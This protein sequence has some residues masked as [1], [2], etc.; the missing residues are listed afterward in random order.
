MAV[1]LLHRLVVTGP[2]EAVADLSRRL[3]R[4]AVRKSGRLTWRERNPFSFRRL[5]QLAP[6]AYRIEPV[7]PY[8]PY[9]ASDWPLVALPG[10]RAEVRYQFSTRNLELQDFVRVLSSQFPIVT[11][12]LLTH[13]LDDGEVAAY[14]VRNGRVRHWLLPEA[15]QDSHWNSARRKF[16][17]SGDDLYENGEA[18][19]FAEERMRAEALAHWVEAARADRDAS[20]TS[21]GSGGTALATT[22]SRRSGS[23]RWRRAG[24]AGRIAMNDSSGVW[25]HLQLTPAAYA[26]FGVA[27]VPIPVRIGAL[28]GQLATGGGLGAEALASEVVAWLRERPDDIETYRPLLG[29]LAFSVG[30]ERGMAGDHKGAV[31]WLEKAA[32][33]RPFDGRVLG[34]FATALVRRGQ[35]A[36]ALELCEQARR[37]PLGVRER[38]H[39]VA[40]ERDC[41][42]ALG[43]EA[44]GAGDL[45][46][47]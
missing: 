17:L 37:L 13:C 25:V 31:Y 1:D 7:I 14:A 12:Y 10:G 11:F 23:L 34:N 27:P 22:T 40:I 36:R 15:R 46:E 38:L 41:R 2:V 33:A 44:T 30:T 35:P 47:G 32:A 16:R 26:N 42:D 28:E 21:L 8:D 43:G 4:R 29:E 24:E 39:F 20:R 3:V 6:D 45:S 18:R 19:S 5:Y 9:D